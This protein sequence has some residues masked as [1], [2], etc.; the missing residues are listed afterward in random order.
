MARVFV[1]ITTLKVTTDVRMVVQATP[2]FL[3]MWWFPYSSKKP[4]MYRFKC[5][6]LRTANLLVV[7]DENTDLYKDEYLHYGT[8]MN[9]MTLPLTNY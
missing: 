5:V 4:K 7:R 9:N 6:W 3:F 2:I 8:S 1:P